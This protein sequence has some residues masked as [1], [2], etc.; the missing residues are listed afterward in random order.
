MQQ[1]SYLIIVS[2]LLLLSLG[3][4]ARGD[5]FYSPTTY[6]TGELPVAALARDFNHDGLLDLV[7]ANQSDDNISVLLGLVGGGF[8]AATNYAAGNQPFAIASGDLDGDGEFDLAVTN[9]SDDSVSIFPGHGDG[10][11]GNPTTFVVQ[12]SPRG[13]VMADLNHDSI[14]DLAV[15]A[16]GMPQANQGWAAVL[17]GLGDGSF[18]NAVLYPA[19]QNPL[20]LTSVDLNGDGDLDL[21]VADENATDTPDDLAIL[22]GNGDGTFPAP[23]LSF[24]TGTASD[25]TAI[26]LNGDGQLRPRHRRRRKQDGE[27]SPRPRRWHLSFA[28]Q[29][30]DIRRRQNCDARQPQ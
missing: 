15:A 11:F 13:I 1:Q 23:L 26:D 3:E 4:I 27:C 22:L 17:L 20:R 29:H 10:T 16:H 14:L 19:G 12:T 18:Q 28:A 25:V 2:T 24:T 7:T 21:A 8:A 30:R 5:R 9:S 6:P